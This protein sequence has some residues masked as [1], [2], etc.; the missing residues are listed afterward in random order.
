MLLRGA[1]VGEV[2]LR[3]TA[4]STDGNARGLAKEPGPV[5]QV[6]MV[7]SLSAGA[8]ETCGARYNGF[9]NRTFHRHWQ[10]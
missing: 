4:A 7:E 2:H 5:T 10:S 8:P 9:Q 3:R 1:W 6:P